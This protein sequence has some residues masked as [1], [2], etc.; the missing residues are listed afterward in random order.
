MFIFRRFASNPQT[1]LP[2]EAFKTCW[3]PSELTPSSLQF[4]SVPPKFKQVKTTCSFARVSGD[5]ILRSVSWGRLAYFSASYAYL[6]LDPYSD[7][8]FPLPLDVW[9]IVCVC[10]HEFQYM[11]YIWILST[12]FEIYF[13]FFL[14]G[15]CSVTDLYVVGE[16][17]HLWTLGQLLHLTVYLIRALWF[18]RGCVVDYT[19]GAK[20]SPPRVIDCSSDVF[21]PWLV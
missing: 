11:I 20:T 8:Y 6:V 15:P 4:L 19:V 16:Y 10:G 1:L 17:T 5:E 18:E 12:D 13:Y 9:C 7:P 3:V 2:L 14:H 21:I